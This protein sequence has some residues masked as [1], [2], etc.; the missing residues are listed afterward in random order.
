MLVSYKWLEKYV[1]LDGISPYDLAE[2]ITRS[3]IEV[4]SVNVLNKDI[5]NVVVG[6]VLLR[7]QHPEAD[8]LSRCQVDVGEENPVQ[9]ICGAR[10]VATGQK[11][12]VAKV[13]AVLPGNFKIK[14]AKLRGEVS[15]GMICSL[16]ELGIESR[17]IAKEFSEGIFVL[18]S[19]APVGTDAMEYLE[20]ADAVLE[21]G[22]TP[23][24][25]DC[26]S[27]FG[28]AYEVAAI[29]G[30]K[31][32]LPNSTIVHGLDNTNDLISVEVETKKENPLYIAK[33]VRNVKVKRS[34]LWLESRLM[35]AGIRPLNNIVD[36]TNYILLEYGQPLHA[37]DYSK[38]DNKKIVVRYATKGEK[39]TT[40]DGIERS[41][42]TTDLVITD[43]DQPIALAGV[44]GGA[45]TEVDNSTVDVLLES[46][47]FDRL[48]VRM[49]SK[50]TGLRSESSARFEKGLDYKRTKDAVLEAAF[51]MQEYAEGEVSEGLVIVNNV[52]NTQEDII[53]TSTDRVN[54]ILGTNIKTEEIRDI[55]DRLGF[56]Y[57]LQDDIN[58]AITIPTRRADITIEV[59]IVEEIGRIYGYD[60]IPAT[61][62]TG[63]TL[64]G[65]LTEKQKLR[66]LTKDVL[67]RTGLSEAITYSL[68]S[69]D[70]VKL[71]NLYETEL[72][73]VRLAM[74]MSEERSTL[75]LSLLPHL[76]D[77]ALYNRNRK[78]ENIS[79]Y[80]IGSVYLPNPSSVQ[81]TEIL[82]LSGLLSGLYTD[83][84]WKGEKKKVDFFV[85]KGILENLFAEL[86][87]NNVIS[88]KATNIE[89]LHPGRT[90]G[91][92]ANET[93]IGFMGQLHPDVEKT[94]S[95]KETYV[96]EISFSELTSLNF[97]QNKYSVIPR[98]PAMARDIAL[99]VDKKVSHS[100]LITV[101][102]NIGK[103]LLKDVKLFDIY[104]GDKLPEGKKSM[105]YSLVYM[106]PERTLTDEEVV[107]V[108]TKVLNALESELGAVLRA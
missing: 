10:N 89:G 58:F 66:R 88:Y 37:F 21:L 51:M 33:M 78:E 70:K 84:S 8:K 4:E 30:K 103:P 54:N 80:E 49:T 98:F 75:R 12:V 104:E 107:K 71:F 72:S 52:T 97:E 56:D 22:L 9:I 16:E 101:I 67:E 92:Y 68:T 105:A 60:A 59:D 40:L 6:H 36:I 62:P 1:D 100:D 69:Q 25:S 83:N 99:V 23:N 47:I 20:F 85:M 102:V 17:V 19:D 74:P 7:E 34:P 95:G 48:T 41:L 24:R 28:V 82:H 73:P 81:P 43:G 26:L 77:V 5:K 91:I 29:L 38:L 15:E 61:L 63:K 32:R 108:H 31:V 2:K 44:M 55:L 57:V 79:I 3:G 86:C 93:L 53:T 106:D 96:F 76:L 14:K 90:A 45:N 94:Y 27:M 64:T 18:P 65:R 46:A 35:K 11:V 42:K 13:G 87:V 39:L 50:E